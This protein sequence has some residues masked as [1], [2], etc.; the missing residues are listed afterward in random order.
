MERHVCEEVVTSK[1]VIDLAFQ[2]ALLAE[3][4]RTAEKALR[5]N[6]ELISTLNGE[7]E[8]LRKGLAPLPIVAPVSQ[9]PPADGLQYDYL[10]H[11]LG[12]RSPVSGDSDS[13]DDEL[14]YLRR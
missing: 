5:A 3:Q 4:L 14:R 8:Q 2:N 9:R 1:V 6:G 12:V 11:D 10:N 13:D 7:N